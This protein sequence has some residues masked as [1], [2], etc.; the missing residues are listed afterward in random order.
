MYCILI[1]DFS[2]IST[3]LTTQNTPLQVEVVVIKVK[4]HVLLESELV[5]KFDAQICI[6][7]P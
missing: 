6:V 1:V 5:F 3:I 7:F 4:V 2:A